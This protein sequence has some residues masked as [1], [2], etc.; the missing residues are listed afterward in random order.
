MVVNHS[1]RPSWG[2]SLLLWTLGSWARTCFKTMKDVLM[3]LV[4]RWPLSRDQK[5]GWVCCEGDKII[6]IYIRII[7]YATVKIPIKQPGFHGMPLRASGVLAIQC[8]A[9]WWVVFKTY[10]WPQVRLFRDH[11]G[12]EKNVYLWHSGV[13]LDS[14]DLLNQRQLAKCLLNCLHH[15]LNLLRSARAATASHTHQ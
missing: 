9:E 1:V 14:H 12:S 11:G 4:G 2:V 8:W 3:V 7:S 15:R 10:N 13:P 6:P 5:P